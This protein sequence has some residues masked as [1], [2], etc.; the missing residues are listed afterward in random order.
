MNTA[1][2]QTILAT[3][4]FLDRLPAS[5]IEKLAALSFEVRFQPEQIIFREGDPSSFF[6][7]IL[8]GH[9][10]L[11]I[12]APGRVLR[13]QTIGEGEELGWSSLLASVNKQFQARCLEPVAALAFDGAQIVALCECDTAFGFRLLRKVLATVADRLR[14][15][16]LQLLDVY[17]GRG[18]GGQ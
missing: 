8:S 6:Y 16:R 5:D 9:I 18:G 4:P 15:T 3:H 13:I 1:Q 10:A 2:V 14:A 11:E 7:L 12:Q 17:A